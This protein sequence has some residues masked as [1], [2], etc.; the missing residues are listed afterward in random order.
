[1]FPA[2]VK[3][4]KKI[5]RN[6]LNWNYSNEPTQNISGPKTHADATTKAEVSDWNGT[7]LR[8]QWENSLQVSKTFYE[9]RY[10]SKKGPI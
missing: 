2:I 7:L 3:Y 6:G 4:V 10:A 8:Y 9:V 5:N 1:M